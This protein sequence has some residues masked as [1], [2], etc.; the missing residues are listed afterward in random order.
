[1]SGTPIYLPD[2]AT[3][4]EIAEI[5]AE[6]RELTFREQYGHLPA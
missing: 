3:P 4:E 2:D 1:M 5:A 6:Q